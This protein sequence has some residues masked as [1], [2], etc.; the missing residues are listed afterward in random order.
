M[1]E[2][3]EALTSATVIWSNQNAPRPELPYV[4]VE[5]IQ[6][7]QVTSD[8]C[9]KGERMVTSM[10]VLYR[11]HYVG[12]E[13]LMNLSL[14]LSGLRE[15]G[16]ATVSQQARFVPAVVESGEWEHRAVAEVSRTTVFDKPVDWSIIDTV[17]V[18]P[19]GEFSRTHKPFEVK[20]G[21]S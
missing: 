7:L 2:S 18:T 19:S 1:I 15:S 20:R 3:I 11:L 16:S 13:P 4:A 9:P 5:P 12:S 21:N 10:R 8:P 6:T 14:I 17:R